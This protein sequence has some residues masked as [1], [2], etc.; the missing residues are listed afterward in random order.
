MKAAESMSDSREEQKRQAGMGQ[1]AVMGV[2]AHCPRGRLV[3]SPSII[4]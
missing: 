2:A 1:D 4:H 3:F